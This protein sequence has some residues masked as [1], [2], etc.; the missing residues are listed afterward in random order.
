LAIA[1]RLKGRVRRTI[2]W[3][4]QHRDE[5]PREGEASIATAVHIDTDFN[6]LDATGVARLIAKNAVDDDVALDGLA[7]AIEAGHRFA[8]V[9]AWRNARTEPVA[10][11]P[12][13]LL[14]T[15]PDAG[16]FPRDAPDLRARRWFVFPG[17]TTDECLLFKQYDRSLAHASDVWHCALGAVG[18][19]DAPPRRSFEV[20][21][22]ILFDDLVPPHLDRFSR[23]VTSQLSYGESACFC[24]EQAD[25][26]A[27]QLR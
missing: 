19:I 25:R 10:R 22:L 7:G 9:N 15:S 5:R 4:A 3:H 6:A 23:R 12:L 2:L 16:Q 21:A 14:A 8:I 26:R 17:M 18:G 27:R 11:A 20:R 13:G 24:G 1:T